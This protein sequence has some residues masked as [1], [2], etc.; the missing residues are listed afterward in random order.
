MVSYY[1]MIHLIEENETHEDSIGVR[2]EDTEITKQAYN[3]WYSLPRFLID[4]REF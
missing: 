4:C 3:S 1:E 2:D